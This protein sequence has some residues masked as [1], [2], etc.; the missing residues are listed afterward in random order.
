REK[1]GGPSLDD[2]SN[3]IGSSCNRANGAPASAGQRA[4]DQDRLKPV[5]HSPD[6]NSRNVGFH[7]KVQDL[8]LPEKPG[9]PSLDD[10]SNDIGTAVQKIK[11]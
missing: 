5:L 2:L 8:V 11:L 10:L 9:G 6:A 4:L 3:D 7:H 1:P